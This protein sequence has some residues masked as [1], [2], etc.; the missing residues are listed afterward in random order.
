MIDPVI[1]KG[2]KN[3]NETRIESVYT[4]CCVCESSDATVVGRGED[5][6]YHT[7]PDT[8]S[9]VRC[10]SCGL[11]YLNPRPTISEFEK[12][13]PPTYHAYNFSKKDFGFVYTVRS[14]LEARR[15]LDHCRNL[16]DDAN[17]LDVGCGDGFHLGLLRRFG[18]RSWNLE[19]I[20]IDKEA[21]DRASEL[22]LKVYVGS[23]DEMDL[24]NENYDLVLLIM[25][26]EHVEYP[27]KVLR[28]I[29]KLLKKGG[30]AV[31]VTDNTDT[32]DFQLFRKHYWGGY[33]FPRHLQLFDRRSLSKLAEKTGFE[34]KQVTTIVSPVNWVISIHNRL[35]G[36][37]RPKWLIRCFTLRSAF[38]L[39]IFT[40]LD[41]ILQ[42]FGKGAV[43]QATLEKPK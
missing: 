5:F 24:P 41:F 34:V 29:N 38:T 6:E 8:F 11:I 1:E 4:R 3:S 23:V 31:I 20:D 16:P 13:Y 9:A 19:G 14:W 37:K 43:L 40:V 39:G 28:R 30:R 26:I 32:I 22:G 33:H 2:R 21:V 25:S 27:D 36:K 7:S 12:F 42:K 17:I 10:N 15:L 18:K 35:V